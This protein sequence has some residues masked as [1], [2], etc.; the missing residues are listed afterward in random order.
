MPST[1]RSTLSTDG[2]SVTYRHGG[3]E[4]ASGSF[5]YTVSDGVETDTATVAITVTPVNDPPPAPSVADQAAVEDEQFS[6][7]FA[8]V[9][10]SGGRRCHVFVGASRR[11]FAPARGLSFKATTR[12]FGGTPREARHTGHSHDR[13]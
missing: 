3:S 9:S 2:A 13:R 4:S 1:A 6:Y 8:A 7:W 11:R 5:T 12:A 10:R